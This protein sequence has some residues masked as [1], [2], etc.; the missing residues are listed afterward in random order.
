MAFFIT[1][2]QFF[3]CLPRAL[4][5]FGILEVSPPWRRHLLPVKES[6]VLQCSWE[7]CQR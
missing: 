1:S 4:L 5:C 3:F 6:C 2:I 7:L